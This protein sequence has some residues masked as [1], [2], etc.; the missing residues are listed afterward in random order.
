MFIV[1]EVCHVSSEV[2]LSEVRCQLAL[3]GLREVAPS[4]AALSEVVVGAWWLV[5]SEMA[6]RPK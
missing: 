1:G 3:G 4:G 6:L 5:L 2:A